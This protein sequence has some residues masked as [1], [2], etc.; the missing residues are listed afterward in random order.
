V[1]FASHLAAGLAGAILA[2]AAFSTAAAPT[3]SERRYRALDS[4]AQVLATIGTDYV[5]PADDATLVRNATRGMVAGLDGY[6]V[7]LAP[8][9]YRKVR[10]DTDGEYGGVGLVF[11]SGALLPGDVPG[12]RQ[13]EDGEPVV[14]DVVP[15]SP[16][17]LAGLA[18]GDH[19]VAIDGSFTTLAGE[20]I[21]ELGTWEEAMRGASGT[22]VRLTVRR[23]GWASPRD[24]VIVRAQ[25]KMPSVQSVALERGIGYVAIS[26]FAEATAADADAALAALKASGDLRALILDLRGDPGG[27][28]DAGVATA[29]LFL[30]SGTI[31]TVHGRGADVERHLAHEA[32]TF[33]GFPM[34]C[35][36]DEGTAS[37]AEIVVGAL[38]DHKRCTVVGMPTYGKG[39][40]QTFFDLDD[41]GGLKLTTARYRS[42]SGASLEGAGITPDVQV[43]GWT[44]EVEVEPEGGPAA[45]TAAPADAAGQDDGRKP[46]TSG[47]P[48]ESGGGVTVGARI[49]A[50]LAGDPQVTTSLEILRRALASKP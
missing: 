5:E 2:S 36:V 47:S 26:R 14:E 23:L 24:L 32:G 15:G 29:D 39:S 22:R 34:V 6:S 25:V 7:Y 12:E 38:R 45:D 21:P 8:E 19:L 10:Q 42:P 40:V 33:A 13:V 3:R 49:K 30:G 4:F 11:G 41:G 46:P 17:D 35:L 1:R 27:L 18:I 20:P 37:A 16:A 28:V 9:H 50:A 44:E 31:V 48:A 43:L